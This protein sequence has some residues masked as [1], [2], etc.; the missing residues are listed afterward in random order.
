MS[1]TMP[2]HAHEKQK[3]LRHAGKGHSMTE[4]HRWT[5]NDQVRSIR[6][7][8]ATRNEEKQDSNSF[9][10]PR[11]SPLILG[12]CPPEQGMNSLLCFQLTRLW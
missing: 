7:A 12:Y 10:A 1:T 11:E 2:P 3:S 8:A 6:D 5:W 4:R 9:R